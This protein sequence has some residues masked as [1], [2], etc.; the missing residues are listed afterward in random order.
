MTLEFAQV[1]AQLVQ[2]LAPWNAVLSD[3]RNVN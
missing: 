1:I 2:A 3:M